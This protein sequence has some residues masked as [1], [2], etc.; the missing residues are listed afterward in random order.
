MLASRQD[1]WQPWFCQFA[2]EAGS[3]ECSDVGPTVE[4][5]GT[6]CLRDSLS[7][8]VMQLLAKLRGLAGRG[9]HT[10]RGSP[11][12]SLPLGGIDRFHEGSDLVFD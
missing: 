6:A 2:R 8:C 12:P 10:V 9:P 4:Q 5:E 1:S 7:E 3:G 11:L